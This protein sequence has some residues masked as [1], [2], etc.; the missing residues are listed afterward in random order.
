MRSLASIPD[1]RWKPA[2]REARLLASPDRPGCRCRRSWRAAAR[3]AATPSLAT[4]RGPAGL[5]RRG[6]PRANMAS[7]SS[8]VGT[9]CSI[10]NMTT[11][12]KR[13]S[14]NGIAVPSPSMTSTFEPASRARQRRPDRGRASM[15]GQLGRRAA[16]G[17]S[18][19]CPV[20]GRPRSTSCA[21]GIGSERIPKANGQ[22]AVLQ[23]L[24]ATRPCRGCRGAAGLI[25]TNGPATR[26]VAATA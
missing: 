10:V 9:W 24:G 18:S 23:G 12:L 16:A 4:E 19:S 26:E 1:R 11:P 20:P 14:S 2:A 6:R 13:R 3:S 17:R 25:R 21:E 22:D 7:C 8:T 15:L 5:Q